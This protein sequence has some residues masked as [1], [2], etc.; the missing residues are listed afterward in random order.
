M[1][2]GGSERPRP[3]DGANLGSLLR[4]DPHHALRRPKRRN[5]ASELSQEISGSR[6]RA[7]ARK[8]RGLPSRQGR[9]LQVSGRGVQSRMGRGLYG[10]GSLYYR[11]GSELETRIGTKGRGTPV[12]EERWRQAGEGHGNPLQCSCLGTPRTEEPGG[13]QS[14]GSQSRTRP[15]PQNNC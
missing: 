6:G 7:H 5:K 10:E 2:A 9:G 15:K 8:G 11:E 12:F 14:L 1:T 4:T 3:W 13:L